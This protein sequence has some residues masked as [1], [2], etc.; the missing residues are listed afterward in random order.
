MFNSIVHDFPRLRTYQEALDYYDRKKPYTKGKNKGLRPLRVSWEGRRSPHYLI[1]KMQDGAIAVQVYD[2]NVL[3]YY[4]DGRV[5]VCT[6]GW[7][8]MTTAS[9]IHRVFCAGVCGSV[10]ARNGHFVMAYINPETNQCEFLPFADAN[11]FSLWLQMKDGAID[12]V[13][14][15]PK[16]YRP[17]VRKDKMAEIR[18]KYAEPI[19]YIVSMSKLQDAK[20]LMITGRDDPLDPDEGRQ[21]LEEADPSSW[22]PL[23]ENIYKQAICMQWEYGHGYV[24]SLTQKRV[25][26]QISKALQFIFNEEVM[27]LRERPAHLQPSNKDIAR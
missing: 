7:G 18:K 9:V 19:K 10:G 17:Y 2:T 11:G 15:P 20:E 22:W 12:K 23:A 8:T 21:L 6:G 16:W 4:S 24:Y 25:R 3:E 14:N 13:L 26:E 5:R 27:E 1:D